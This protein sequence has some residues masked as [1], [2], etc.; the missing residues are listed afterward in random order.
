MRPALWILP[1]ALVLGAVELAQ[2]DRGR[3]AELRQEIEERETRARALA[4]EAVGVLGE[5][6]AIDRELHELRRSL[7]LLRERRRTAETEL[8]EART[9]LRKAVDQRQTLGE[10]VEKRLIALYK[11]YAT[12]GIP[13]LYSAGTFQQLLLR[14]EALGRV[15]EE[16][17]RLFA[18]YGAAE[19]EWARSRDRAE[20]L[21]VEIE[22]TRHEVSNREDRV[23]Q[24]LVE[25]KNVVALLQTRADRE[26]R[27][28]AE[29]REA[30]E[31]LE[32]LLDERKGVG[33]PGHGL[34]RGAV[35]PPLEGSVRLGFGSQR[36]PEFGT[37]TLRNGIEISSPPGAEVRAVGPARVLFAGWF[38]GYGQ[39]VILDHGAEDVSVSGYLA[40]RTVQAGAVVESGEVIGRV[41]ESGSLSGPGLYFEIRHNGKPVDP[42]EW[43]APSGGRGRR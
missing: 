5:L 7:R 23:R 13:A 30:A 42:G 21:L 9:Q 22:Q 8:D 4:D 37:R 31:R 32:R 11:F 6:E 39:I 36:D 24:S 34:E 19:Q 20:G 40:E 33:S 1:V 29:L 43:F 15:L 35:P 18:R 10:R 17:E 27:A 12:G 41:G 28:A 25:R 14:R 26:R 3:L 2:A 38:K 16:D